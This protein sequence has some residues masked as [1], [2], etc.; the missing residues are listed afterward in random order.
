[1]RLGIAFLIA[2]MTLSAC[3]GDGLRDLQNNSTG[4]DEFIVEPK[5]EL[6]IPSE[7]SALPQPTPGQT[8]RTD[9]DPAADM[10][11]ALGGRPDSETAPIPARDGALVTAASRNGVTPNIRTQLA[12]ED[13]EYRRKRGRFSNIKLFPEDRY[14]DVY[15][16]LALDARDTA[17]AWRRAGADTPSYPPR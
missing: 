14:V 10:I 7:L 16:P 4:P 13:A 11:V 3:A 15:K 9:N 6:E 2:G 12:E 5:G 17:D 1:M 8:N